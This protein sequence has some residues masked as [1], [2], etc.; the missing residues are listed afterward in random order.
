MFEG[1]GPGSDSARGGGD[2]GQIE[3]LEM[4]S[5]VI[6]GLI[7]DG[8]QD[9]LSLVVTR[10][11][12]VGFTEV[13]E[14]DG[15]VDGR[16]DVGQTDLGRR[17]GEGVATTDPSL[18]ANESGAFQRQENLFEIGLGESGSRGDVAHGGRTGVVFVQGE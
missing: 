13:S 16:H 8:Q 9:A 12:G 3:T 2:V 6:T 17:S 1:F 5:H 18:R 7:P 15:A 11:I 14:S 10:T 4:V